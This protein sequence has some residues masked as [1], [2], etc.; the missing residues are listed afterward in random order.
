MTTPPPSAAPPSEATP[1]SAAAPRSGPRPAPWVR[2]RLRAAPL[3]TLLAAALAFVA[4]LLAAALPRAQDRGA[5]QALRS[6]LEG[7]GQ[8]DTSLQVTALAPMSGQSAEA[9][10]GTLKSLLSH[11]GNTF[12]VDPD[13][14]VHGTRTTKRQPLLNPELS[15]PHRLPP[16][17][18]LLYFKQAQ[19]HVKLVEGRWPSD[20]PGP[21]E[22]PRTIRRSRSPCRSR[23]PTPSTPASGPSSRARP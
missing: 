1:P 22:P 7:S 5:D 19:E 23:P 14:V 15:R 12:R 2:T 9:L 10:D 20:T 13:A 18:S 21:P 3:G 11:T 6:F 4:V 8:S 17:M 16:E